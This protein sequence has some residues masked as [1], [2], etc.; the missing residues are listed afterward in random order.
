LAGVVT[1]IFAIWHYIA[2]TGMDHAGGA[3]MADRRDARL[4]AVR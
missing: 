3:T 4:A 1:G 2:I